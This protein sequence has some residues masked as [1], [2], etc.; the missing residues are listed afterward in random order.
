MKNLRLDAITTPAIKDLKN[1]F[2]SILA[3]I[4]TRKKETIFYTDDIVPH[5]VSAYVERKALGNC[6]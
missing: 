6:F 2:I 1:E 4:S 5:N 3:N